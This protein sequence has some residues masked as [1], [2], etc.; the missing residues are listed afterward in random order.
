MFVEERANQ[1]HQDYYR[2]ATQITHIQY[3]NREEK[4]ALAWQPS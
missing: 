2:A 4:E 3:G 1:L